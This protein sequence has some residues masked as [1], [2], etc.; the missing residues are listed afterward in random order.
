MSMGWMQRIRESFT[1]NPLLWIIAALLA[2]AEFGSYETGKDLVRLCELTGPHD[3][4]VPRRFVRD[5]KQEI[6]NIC[7]RHQPAD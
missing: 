3:V 6:D 1:Q 5:A 2:L 4:S 7:I